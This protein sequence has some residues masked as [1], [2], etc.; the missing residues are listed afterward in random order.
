M[1]EKSIEEESSLQRLGRKWKTTIEKNGKIIT[2]A[3]AQPMISSRMIKY[4][5]KLIQIKA[6]TG[7]N[8]SA[9]TRY[10]KKKFKYIVS[11]N[12]TKLLVYTFSGSIKYWTLK[13]VKKNLTLL[14]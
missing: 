5:L 11:F 9:I 14:T 12:A 3:N 1:I 4:N 8:C 7:A 6:L 10:G 13:G 2:M